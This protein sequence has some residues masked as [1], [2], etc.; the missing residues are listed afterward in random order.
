[1]PAISGP[2]STAAPSK[3]KIEALISGL[4]RPKLSTSSVRMV[5]SPSTFMR[6]PRRILASWSP[7]VPS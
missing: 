4:V 3:L 6:L 5:S 7:A 1:M 2:A